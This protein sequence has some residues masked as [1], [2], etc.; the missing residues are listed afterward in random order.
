M[1]VFKRDPRTGRT[2]RGNQP[3]T[4]GYNFYHKGKRYIQSLPGITSKAEAKAIEQAKR[5][6]VYSGIA[7]QQETQRTIEKLTDEIADLRRQLE[8]KDSNK[9]G[10]R[11]I[12]FEKFAD[13]F[14]AHK[15]VANKQS[16]NQYR[17]SVKVYKAQWAGQMLHT[18]TT[19]DVEAFRQTRAETPTRFKRARAKATLDL[20][21]AILSGLFTM[22]I[23]QG[24]IR[25]NPC[26][27]VKL[28]KPKNRRLD[29]LEE[30]REPDFFNA[31]SGPREKY[32]T[33]A[34]LYM[35]TGLRLRELSELPWENVNLGENIKERK[36]EVLGKGRKWRTVPLNN[37][38][39]AVFKDLRAVCNG[40]GKVFANMTAVGIANAITTAFDKIGLPGLTTHTLRHTFATRLAR[41]GDVNAEQLRVLLGHSNIATT[42]RYFHLNDESLYGAV[43]KLDF[44]VDCLTGNAED[45]Q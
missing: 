10:D 4:W 33:V 38:A 26:S 3:G 1:S 35:H 16:E 45:E 23:E 5:F 22:A 28:Y 27:G 42:Q 15:R 17:G 7:A 13:I 24:Y 31:L 32:K 25:S 6:E 43:G 11:E 41:R 12:L 9:A 34:L 37:T 8:S 30:D 14:F 20:E 44:P 2:V 18:I 21:I 29:I 39:Y 40:K 19:A 36:I